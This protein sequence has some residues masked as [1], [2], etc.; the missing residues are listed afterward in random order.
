MPMLERKAQFARGILGLG[1]QLWRW[2]LRQIHDLLVVTEIYRQEF[3]M[4][5]QCQTADHQRC[6]LTHEK[7]GEEEAAHVFIATSGEGFDAALTL[8]GTL[9]SQA[10]ALRRCGAAALD[11]A[12]V[13]AGRCDAMVD[14]GLAPW[15]VAAGSLL[16][17]E[18]GG[19]VTPFSG[20]GDVLE[21]RECL[22][23]NPG[24]HAALGE[25]LRA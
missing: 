5:V 1:N 13:A 6:E 10:S 19:L 16:V 25:I 20:K 21:A 23:A 24:L 4:P 3:G 18:A 9:L 17:Q 15:D 7:V 8:L 11:L 14:R 12:Q 2:H 22:A